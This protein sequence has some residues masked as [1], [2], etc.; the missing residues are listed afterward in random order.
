MPTFPHLIEK[1]RISAQRNARVDRAVPFQMTDRISYFWEAF[2][3]AVNYRGGIGRPLSSICHIL[4]AFLN[5]SAFRLSDR[6]AVGG[7]FAPP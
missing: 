6:R 7:L 2:E 3:L 4:L 1:E 5:P